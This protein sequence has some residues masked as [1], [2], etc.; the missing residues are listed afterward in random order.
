MGAPLSIS[1]EDV[2]VPL[3]LPDRAMSAGYGLRV[4]VSV[5]RLLAKVVNCK[6]DRALSIAQIR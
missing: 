4:H 1:D 2:T 3:P 5:S 6:S